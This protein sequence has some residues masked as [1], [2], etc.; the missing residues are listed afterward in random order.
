M[1]RPATTWSRL[2]LGT[3]QLGMPY[4]INNRVGPPTREAAVRLV[5]FALRN[6]V[7]AFD[8]SPEYGD[9]ESIL[10]AALRER[11]GVVVVSKLPPMPRMQPT[12]RVLRFV[13]EAVE[14]T[15]NRLGRRRL[16]AYLFHRFEDLVRE[17]GAL[18]RHLVRW[19]DQGVIAELGVSVYTPEEA[20]RALRTP[21]ID[22][23]QVPFNLCDRR[24][25]GSG[26][27]ERARARGVRLLARSPFLQG[28][29]FKQD[30]PDRLQAF[31]RHREAL[32]GLSVEAGMS[33]GELAL[34]YALSYEP[35][36]SVVLG[37]EAPSQLRE[38]LAWA[39]NGPLPAA[40]RARV[41]R[42]P[43]PP[44]EILDPRQW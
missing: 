13:D 44:T 28:L 12:T 19:R 40:L 22:V 34:R 25:L 1:P 41:E 39:Q 17:N 29:I 38:N 16:Q 18:L 10:G 24:L 31:Q 6:G 4:G 26:F 32:V 43:M 37:V 30:L 27:L 36:T 23:I 15:F 11:P 2:T 9:S 14:G 21:E 42:L 5:R 20:E 7:N 33:L 35:I 3:A 8:T